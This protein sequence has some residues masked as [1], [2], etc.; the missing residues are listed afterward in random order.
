M[1]ILL[2]PCIRNVDRIGMRVSRK[3]CAARPQEMRRHAVSKFKTSRDKRH[4][5]S[6]G[7]LQESY[8]KT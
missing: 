3:S 2:N 8:I 5:L 7:I 1:K 6:S 4:L